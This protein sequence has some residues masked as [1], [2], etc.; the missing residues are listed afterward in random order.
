MMPEERIYAQALRLA[1]ELEPRKQE[2]LRILC[3]GAA[4]ALAARL[5]AG[6]SP[7]DCV[8]DFVGAASMMALAD[9]LETGEADA[10]ERFTAGEM[11]IQKGEG[12]SAAFCLRA[13]AEKRMAP[14]LRDSFS[15][16]GV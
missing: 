16:R 15:F 5:R 10:P 12:G 3:E 6:V 14:Y 11:T 9:F 13:G 8:S 4:A 7:G 2:L 1:G